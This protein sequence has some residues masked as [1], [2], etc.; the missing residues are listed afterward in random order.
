VYAQETDRQLG[1]GPLALAPIAI[2][3]VSKL[4]DNHPKDKGRLT[5]NAKA[6]NS[7]ISGNGVAV[8]YLKGRAGRFGSVP[9][10]DNSMVAIDK[11]AK[12]GAKVGGWATALAKDDAYTK[13][14][15]VAAAVPS[16][17]SQ[18]SGAYSPAPVQQASLFG[19]IPAPVLIGGGVLA[20]V[21]LLRRK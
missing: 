6:Y 4:F 2:N 5:A 3:V 14:S 11:D 13:Y 18:A 10:L 9:M 15:D 20:L 17:V 1:I 16:A 19:G 7:A 8:D 21:F 12:Q